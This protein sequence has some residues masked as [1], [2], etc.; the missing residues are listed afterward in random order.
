[1]DY[2]LVEDAIDK[3]RDSDAFKKSCTPDNRRT[4]LN[5]AALQQEYIKKM[6]QATLQS[7]HFLINSKLKISP[8]RVL[9]VCSPY[10]Q[11]LITTVNRLHVVLDGKISWEEKFFKVR[12]EK[13]FYRWTHTHPQHPQQ[14]Y[15]SFSSYGISYMLDGVSSSSLTPD[16]SG[17]SGVFNEQLSERLDYLDKEWKAAWQKSL[18]DADQIVGQFSG[19]NTNKEAL[20]F[21]EKLRDFLSKTPGL[22]DVN[23]DTMLECMSID[24]DDLDDL[25]KFLKRNKSSLMFVRRED[26][27]ES[28]KVAQV[29]KIMES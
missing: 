29:Q 21:R 11:N 6:R 13:F 4:K 8:P 28:Q 26:F 14:L 3:L 22:L 19:I 12:G 24:P 18:L 27:E 23:P 2:K 1:M 10:S 7:W 5:Q 15:L 20:K 16:D 25:V 17:I 9:K